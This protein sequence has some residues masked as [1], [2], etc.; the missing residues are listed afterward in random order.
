MPTGERFTCLRGRSGGVAGHSLHEFDAVAERLAKLD[1][2]VAGDR[3]AL[4]Q[5]HPG[6]LGAALA[7]R[8][9]GASFRGVFRAVRAVFSTPEAATSAM[10]TSNT[11]AAY[12]PYCWIASDIFFSSCSTGRS[13]A[14]AHAD[15]ITSA[16]TEIGPP[17][18]DHHSLLKKVT[19]RRGGTFLPR[20]SSKVQAVAQERSAPPAVVP[21]RPVVRIRPE[22]EVV[23]RPTVE[24]R[25]PRPLAGG[26]PP[27]R[28]P[29]RRGPARSAV[30]R[31]A[32]AFLTPPA[33]ILFRA[34]AVRCRFRSPSHAFF[35]CKVSGGPTTYTRR[36]AHSTGR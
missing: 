23:A 5:L 2:V 20:D 10:P 6:N 19:V 1:A 4:D 3:N 34:A 29:G 9:V 25:P 26:R 36:V 27:A 35:S 12:G 28:R 30:S 7:R 21:L 8:E 33:E 32:P 18:L 24:A 16:P 14:R 31:P 11:L 17:E 22:E 13:S 15:T